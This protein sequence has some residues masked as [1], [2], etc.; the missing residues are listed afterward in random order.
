MK[1]VMMRSFRHISGVARVWEDIIRRDLAIV[2]QAIRFNFV[3]K[4]YREHSRGGG[5]GDPSSRR[6]I[7]GAIVGRFMGKICGD[8]RDPPSI[9]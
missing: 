8:G 1:I 5:G 3:D 6:L 7:P 9:C 2:L 4:M